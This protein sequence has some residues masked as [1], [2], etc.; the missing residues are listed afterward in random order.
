MICVLQ[1]SDPDDESKGD[2]GRLFEKKWDEIEGYLDTVSEMETISRRI[3]RTLQPTSSSR[4]GLSSQS[5]PACR[6]ASSQMGRDCRRF[7]CHRHSQ[8]S[9]GR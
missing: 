5:C 6:P 1:A 8:Q 4:W 2:F 3:P 7:R 9:D